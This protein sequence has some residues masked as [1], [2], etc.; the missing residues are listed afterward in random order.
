MKRL[1][2]LLVVLAFAFTAPWISGL[3]S[4]EEAAFDKY[5]N[6]I[7]YDTFA[8][9]AVIPVRDDVV[10]VDSRPSKKKYDKGHVPGAINIPNTF[11]DKMVDKLPQD[12]A[13]ALIFYCGGLKCPLSHKSAFKAEALGYTN[14]MVYAEG[15]PVWKK[16]GNF[17]SVSEKFIKK[18]VDKPDGSVIVEAR[19]AR[20]KYAKGHVPTAINIPNTFFDKMT[21]KLPADKNTRLIF[22]CG[23]PKC[24][25]SLKSATKAKAL[26]YT[27]VMLFQAGYPAWKKAYGAGDTAGATA[28]AAKKAAAAPAIQAGPEGDT[29]TIES[30]KA[31]MSQA[32]DSVHLIDVRDPK[33]Y[34]KAHFKNV[35]NIPVEDLEDQVAD[36]P[37]DKPIVFV[38]ATGARSSEAYD[39]VKMVRADMQVYYLDA[40]IDFKPDGAYEV[41]ANE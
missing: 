24:P 7:D 39:I 10:I 12:K 21:D 34:Q 9:Y 27:N 18:L 2:G 35:K 31:V 1:T 33:E 3:A 40:E 26:G 14:V 16:K 36:L 25:L 37:S 6:I 29:I 23:G 4:A 17:V 20:K 32:P 11:F 5:K 19:P 22:Y 8:T 13:T 30:F 41:R 28:P 15:F 38:C